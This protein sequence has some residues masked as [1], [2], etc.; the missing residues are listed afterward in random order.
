[1]KLG[2]YYLKKIVAGASPTAFLSKENNIRHR[3][4]LL[5]R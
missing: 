5:T 4:T 3:I 1:V 2:F